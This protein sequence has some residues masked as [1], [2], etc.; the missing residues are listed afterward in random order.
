MTFFHLSVGYIERFLRV[1][2]GRSDSYYIGSIFL[3]FFFQEKL[4]AQIR[5]FL[6]FILVERNANSTIEQPKCKGQKN[7]IDF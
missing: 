3:S 6:V 4:H 1:D 7:G 5:F 2:E